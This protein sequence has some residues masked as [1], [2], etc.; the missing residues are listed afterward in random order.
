[1]RQWRTLAGFSLFELV[2][3]LAILGLLAGIAAPRVSN[4]L[5]RQRLDMAS[6]RLMADLQLVRSQAIHDGA[7]RSLT[8]SVGGQSYVLPAEAHAG[9][10]GVVEFN[11]SPYD[12]VKLAGTSFDPPQIAYN[13][14]GLPQAGGTITFSAGGE[15][16]VVTISASSGR[17]TRT[18]GP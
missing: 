17:V 6:R 8:L 13:R 14:L 7:D 4:V 12:D 15:R 9:T 16:A 5:R 3:V 2:M 1:M 10:G 18:L 11:T